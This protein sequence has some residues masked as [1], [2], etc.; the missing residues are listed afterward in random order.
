MANAK[1]C[2]RCGAFYTETVDIYCYHK[3]RL[4]GCP[5]P[6]KPFNCEYELCPECWEEFCNFIGVK[7]D[8][9]QAKTFL[10]RIQQRLNDNIL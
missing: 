4:F 5:L 10:N 6:Q 2:D 9:K 1:Q 8:R 3:I 7:I